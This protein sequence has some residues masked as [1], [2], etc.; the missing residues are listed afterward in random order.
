M[1]EIEALLLTAY[2]EGGWSDVGVIV[3][4]S[5]GADSVA[6]LRG[7]AA[8]RAKLPGSGRLMAAHFNHALRGEASDLDEAF[9]AEL[10]CT[11]KLPFF[12]GKAAP[13]MHGQLAEEAA[14]DQRYAFLL[15]TANEQGARVIVTA[16]TASDQAETVLHRVI[17]GSGIAGL[18]GI[19]VSRA[20]SEAVT[21]VRPLLTAPRSQIIHYLQ[22]VEQP[23]RTDA[24]NAAPV[25]TR[26]KI[27]LQLLPQLRQQ[28]NPQI[29]DA[30]LHLA[31]IG[32][33]YRELVSMLVT[34]LISTAVVQQSAARL[35][36]DCNALSTSPPLLTVE[37]LKHLWQQHHWPAGGMGYAQWRRLA[38]MV[39]SPAAAVETLPANI[40]AQKQDGQLVLNRPV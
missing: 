4:V 38:A 21:L 1:Q 18:A 32:S 25:Y 5:G 24:T 13:P 30:L 34:G 11:L 27:R 3:A 10:A 17:R 33:E 28:Y 26:N 8:A 16:H 20:L 6:L 37:L 23:Y 22:A 2:R 29:D 39:H 12:C 15:R 7:M 35:V 19:P 9:V 31:D 36:L 40:R 14:R